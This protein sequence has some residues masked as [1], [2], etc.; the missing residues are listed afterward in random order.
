M[1][2]PAPALPAPTF[3]PTRVLL[4]GPYDPNCGE[5]TFLAP[6]LGVWRLAGV[7][8]ASG[9][10]AVVFDPNC[11]D[12]DPAKEL[13]YVLRQANW[14]VVGFSTTGMT[15]RFDLALAHLTRKTSPGS[16][17]VAGGM[18]ATF[19]PDLMFQLGPFDLVVLGE[20]ERP[21][22]EIVRRL[23][24][25]EDLA[26]VLGTA[27]QDPQ[28]SL[29]RYPQPALTREE[30]RDAIF[31]TPYDQ[32]PYERY[33][34]RLE[35]SCRIRRLPFKADREA[36][37]SEIR[38]VRLITLNYCP[39]GCTFC[40]STNF[41]NEAQDSTAR[42]A[43]LDPE[44]CMTMIR[45]IVAAHPG[46][47][48]I[49]FQDDIFVFISDKRVLP[50]CEAIVRAKETGDLPRDLQFISTNRIDAMNPQ[51][52]AAM[53]AA[54]FRVLGF[55]IE[56]FS[57]SVL[58]EFNKAKIYPHIE[59]TLRTA[60]DLG[61]TPF[62]DMILTSPRCTLRDLAETIRQAYRW[63]VAGCEVGMYPYVIP[64][65]GAAMA[66]DPSLLAQTVT[67]THHIAGTDR[68]WEQPSKI[69]P[70]DETVRSA[71]LEIEEVFERRLKVLEESVA[72]LPSRVRS[73][74]WVVCA[75]PVLQL[76]GE[77]M[78]D[79]NEALTQLLAHLP[80]SESQSQDAKL[81]PS[82]DAVTV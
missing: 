9:I 66:R 47:R 17:L 32:M 55:G 63:V 54:G 50:L 41:L 67:T 38:S 49:I 70:F 36:R 75:I 42:I 72:H 15:L 43:R 48:T 14:D 11:C 25:A 64:F 13:D 40:S 35:E 53:R 59:P 39:M 73:L 8:Q 68:S 77:E 79:L 19:R 69:L 4:V 34:K 76:A 29:R 82:L 33:W 80:G 5:F 12:R 78:P 60:L 2:L 51:R 16:L 27:Y 1:R 62:L 52:L 10:R 46:V 74:L 44:E 22:L 18:E 7:L 24:A 61:I 21:L 37:L 81:F 31:H 30:L 57:L 6:P 3:R 56:N 58:T 20:G 26:G 71:I 28:G 65:S 23:E 45:R